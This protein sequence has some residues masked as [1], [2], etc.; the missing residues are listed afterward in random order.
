MA[1]AMPRFPSEGIFSMIR[2]FQRL[3]YFLVLSSS[4]AMAQFTYSEPPPS[5][6]TKDSMWVEWLI[7]AVCVVGCLVIAFKPAKR[8]NLE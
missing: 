2:A 4:T 8:S 5:A 7:A 6:V 3:G 1:Q